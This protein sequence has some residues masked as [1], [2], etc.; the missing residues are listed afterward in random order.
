MSNTPENETKTDGCGSLPLATGS[1]PM[2][3]VD[4]PATIRTLRYPR[5][6]MAALGRFS[7]IENALIDQG[8]RMIENMRY[9]EDCW[10]SVFV[11]PNSDY[12]AQAQISKT[13]SD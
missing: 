10:R 12:S 9:D 11:K 2:P 5:G 1:A 4:V 3:F 7:Q 8:W 6:D 13:A